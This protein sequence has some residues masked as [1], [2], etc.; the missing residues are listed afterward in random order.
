MRGAKDKYDQ[1]RAAV[2]AADGQGLE[3]GQ[4]SACG[5]PARSELSCL[6]VPRCSQLRLTCCSPPPAHSMPGTRKPRACGK[7]RTGFVISRR[8]GEA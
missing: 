2:W 4:L 8:C 3:H 7:D 1:S 6:Q 5:H